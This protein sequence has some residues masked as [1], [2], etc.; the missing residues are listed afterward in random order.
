MANTNFYKNKIEPY[1]RRW[2]SK[3]FQRPFESSETALKLRP[4]GIHKF[5]AVSV[6]RRVVAGVRSSIARRNTWQE[7]GKIKATYTEI[8]FLSQVRAQKRLLVF[9]NKLFF[10]KFTKRSLLRYPRSVELLYCP[11]PK[12]LS[13]GATHSH[14]KSS[15]EI[16]KRNKL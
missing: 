6:D 1:V 9:T 13:K 14:R 11:L 8:F 15:K 5:D 10:E 7:G 16:G 2:L 4:G 3:K 12:R